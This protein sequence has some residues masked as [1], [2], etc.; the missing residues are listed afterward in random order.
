MYFSRMINTST[1]FVCMLTLL[2]LLIFSGF[3]SHENNFFFV[4]QFKVDVV[5]M[6]YHLAVM[7]YT[8]K[9]FRVWSYGI[10]I[11]SDFFP[12]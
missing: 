10:R 5:Y 12:K 8:I 9:C 11:V 6:L 2:D 7:I 4:V 1:I 3:E